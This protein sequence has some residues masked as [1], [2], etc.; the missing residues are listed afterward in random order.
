MQPADAGATAVPEM[1]G[2][3]GPSVS[4]N[5]CAAGPAPGCI[6]GA[7]PPTPPYFFVSY[8]PKPIPFSAKVTAQEAV[9]ATVAYFQNLQIPED[10]L[11]A[12]DAPSQMEVSP[13]PSSAPVD[14]LAPPPGQYFLGDNLTDEQ[15]KKLKEWMGEQVVGKVR[16]KPFD[17][18]LEPMKKEVQA[19]CGYVVAAVATVCFGPG[20]ELP[21]YMTGAAA[22]G[23]A[24]DWSTGKIIDAATGVPQAVPAQQ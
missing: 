10:T 14:I 7:A 16:D 12:S 11:S 23:I 5:P 4:Q 24:F 18:M 9:A 21:G 17:K 15:Q 6:L 13:P 1:P 22:G 8:T 3:P 20:A 2:S 19:I